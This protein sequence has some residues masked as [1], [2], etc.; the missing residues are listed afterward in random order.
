M[1]TTEPKPK[2]R[3]LTKAQLEEQIGLMEKQVLVFQLEAQRAIGF[4]EGQIAMLQKLLKE[5]T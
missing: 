4:D 1:E 2:L 5:V 3:E